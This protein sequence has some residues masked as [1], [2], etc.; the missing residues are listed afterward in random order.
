M[1]EA[2][3]MSS[4]KLPMRILFGLVMITVLLLVFTITSKAAEGDVTVDITNPESEWINEDYEVTVNVTK[5]NPDIEI[6][7][8]TAHMDSGSSTNITTDLKYTVNSNGTLYITVKDTN[9]ET[10]DFIFNI[11]YFDYEGPELIGAIDEG[12]LSLE[13]K[14][15]KA[16]VNTLIINGFEYTDCPEG[17][18]NIRLRQFDASIETFSIYATDMLGNISEE[19]LIANPYYQTDEEKEDADEDLSAY[20]PIDA[21]NS[22]ITSSV[23]T[24]TLHATEYGYTEGAGEVLDVS[25]NRVPDYDGMEFYV[26]ETKSGKTFYMVIDKSQADNNA[27]L[28]TEAD[29]ADLL[30]FTGVESKVLPKN[31]AVIA[32][33]YE[34]EEGDE[35]VI[36]KQGEFNKSPSSIGEDEEVEIKPKKSGNQNMI[37]V[38]IVVVV[39]GGIVFFMKKKKKKEV[40]SVDFPAFEDPKDDEE[41]E[42]SDDEVVGDESEDD[43]ETIMGGAVL[44]DKPNE[45]IAEGNEDAVE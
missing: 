29:E 34:G 14:D 18:L 27:Y 4:Y 17:L 30:N 10:Y 43:G 13:V 6:K 38:A 31:A 42:L 36:S 28:L 8:V 39:F 35:E 15:G 1:L 33:S 20:L 21:E 40:D 11:G 37:M 24:V 26:V 41:D 25:G 16:G 32:G 23:G 12:V 7:S 3:K 45:E 5:V 22:A 2:N 19:Y 9:G 44:A